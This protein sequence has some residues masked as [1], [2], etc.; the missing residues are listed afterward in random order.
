MR[1]RATTYGLRAL[2]LVYLASASAYGVAIALQSGTPWAVGLRAAYNDA[3]PVV[4]SWSH[5]A[6]V[7]TKPA[8]DWVVAE[9]KAF[10]NSSR[11][12]ASAGA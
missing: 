1:G 7:A 9:D 2:S 11:P 6:V 8:V 5:T 12:A 4:R 3:E 10:F